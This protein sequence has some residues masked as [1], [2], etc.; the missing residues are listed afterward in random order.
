M[1]KR[2]LPRNVFIFGIVSFLTDVS[3]EMI[4]PL[5]PMFLTT[6]LGTSASFLGLI[7]GIAEATAS[8]L[9][10]VSG[11]ISDRMKKKK[12]LV[13][14]GYGISAISKPTIGLASHWLH[15]LLARF[16]DRT[17]KGIR[18]S[19]RDALIAETVDRSE[20]GKAFGFHRAMDT[21]GAVLGPLLAFGLLDI[22]R[23]HYPD[24]KS[25]RLVFLLAFIPAVLAVLVL[26]IFIK[27][28]GHEKTE[29]RPFFGTIA[30]LPSDFKLYLLVMAT[31]ALGNSSD[32][33][34]LLRSQNLGFGL[35]HIP[36]LYSLF[37]IVYALTA[38]PLGTLSDRIGR[39]NTLVLGFITYAAVYLGFALTKSPELLWVLWALYGVYYGFTEGVGRAFVADLVSEDKRGTAYGVYHMTTGLLLFPAS[40]IAGVLWDRISPRAPFFLGSAMALLSA[41]LIVL[42][43]SGRN[44]GRMETNS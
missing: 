44:K 28:K 43:F 40:F 26:I 30:S 2:G 15:V 1:K 27:E 6:V 37:N 13:V 16:V 34:L 39:K 9:K 38:M 14:A 23:R 31:F 8:V 7:E 35:T 36:L 22:F 17:G 33:F 4:Y 21:L 32:T 42:V 18:T 11:Y 10:S 5:I 41:I 3:S 19:P 24:A 20:R 25:L 12:P 29:K